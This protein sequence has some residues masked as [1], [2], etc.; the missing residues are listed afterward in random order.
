MFDWCF[1]YIGV[2]TWVMVVVMVVVVVV[3]VVISGSP[4]SVAGVGL[5]IP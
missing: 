5:I 4:C 2:V 1:F 3:V